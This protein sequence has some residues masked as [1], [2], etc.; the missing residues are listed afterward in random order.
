[1]DRGMQLYFGDGLPGGLASVR[2]NRNGKGTS[3]GKI[4]R[5]LVRKQ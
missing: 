3:I 2:K 4:H 1:M 5:H